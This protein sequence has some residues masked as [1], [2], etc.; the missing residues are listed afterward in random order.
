MGGALLLAIG[1]GQTSM[2]VAFRL[3]MLVAAYA[4]GTMPFTIGQ[5]AFTIVIVVLFNLLVPVGWTVGLLRVEDVA[6]GCAVSAV[7]GVLF[8]PRGAASLVADDL[9][10]PFRPAPHHL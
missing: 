6:I 4:P 10:D 8:W 9:P 2:W 7:V 1:T 5:A 3:A